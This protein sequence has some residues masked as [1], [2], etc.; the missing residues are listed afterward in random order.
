MTAQPLTRPSQG[1]SFGDG[2]SPVA[3]TS[4]EDVMYSAGNSRSRTPLPRDRDFS[5]PLIM[6]EYACL[7]RWNARMIESQLKNN[8]RG[9]KEAQDHM[10]AARCRIFQLE[11]RA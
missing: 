7:E 10:R 2:S 8:M 9:V 5:S 11:Q 6:A 1:Q 4:V 3:A